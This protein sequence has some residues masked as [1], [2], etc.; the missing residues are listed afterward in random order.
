MFWAIW[1]Q[2]RF[3]EMIIAAIPQARRSHRPCLL[4]TTWSSLNKYTKKTIR[5]SLKWWFEMFLGGIWYGTLMNIGY[6]MAQAPFLLWFL[7]PGE[8]GCSQWLQSIGH[9]HSAGSCRGRR[10]SWTCEGCD[11]A[12]RDGGD[13]GVWL[14]AGWFACRFFL[15]M[16]W[17]VVK[18]TLRKWHV[19]KRWFTF[20]KGDFPIAVLYY[21]KVLN[22]TILWRKDGT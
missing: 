17:P 12:H 19:K 9:G 2:E 1:I 6:S 4:L 21:Q 7:G 10:N 22:A 18:N 8:A 20:E 3:R 11:F 14:G 5:S 16:K 15:G 13:L